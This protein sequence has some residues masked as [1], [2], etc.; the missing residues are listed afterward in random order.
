MCDRPLD[1]AEA[2]GDAVLGQE[3]L[4]HYVGVAPMTSEAL[5][6]PVPEPVE[7][8]RP[9]RYRQGCPSAELH[10]ALHRV[11]AAAELGRDPPRAPAQRV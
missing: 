6:E 5:S 2:D 1:G 3:L 11:P 8:A 9:A 4:P 10:V 7:G